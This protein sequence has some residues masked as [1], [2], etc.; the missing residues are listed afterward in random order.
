MNM[1][2]IAEI[3]CGSYY[4]VK[5]AV[6][7][8][9]ERVELN[10]ALTLGGLT[11]AETELC[12]VKEDFSIKVIAMLRPRGAG[13]C[14]SDEEFRVMERECQR[15]LDC[16]ADGIAF[17]CLRED[18]SLDEY[19][20][21]CILDLIK[22]KGR[23][24]VFHRA[25]DCTEFPL[26]AAEQLISIGVDR[27]LT[28]GLKPKAMEGRELLCRL[29]ADYGGE[30]QILAGSGIHAGNVLELIEYTGIHQIHSSCKAWNTDLTTVKNGVSYSIASG[31]QALCYDVVSAELVRELVKRVQTEA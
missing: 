29:Q 23:E 9:A 2:R 21:R 30:I 25:F 31:K 8:G 16:G 19:K 10:S 24:A 27:V 22:N 5:Q 28:S 17:G 18:A 20:N 3:C 6:E 7:G 15:L 11:P 14:Y 13:F 26:A 12:M 1:K 4:D